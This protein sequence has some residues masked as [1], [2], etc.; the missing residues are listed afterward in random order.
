VVYGPRNIPHTFKNVGTTPAR[1]LA[2]AKPAGIEEFL[3]EA[4]EVATN[5]SFPPFG[6]EEIERFFATAPKYGIEILT[7][8]G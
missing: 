2:F 3:E 1:M 8:S 4:G 6:Q 5:K 7:P